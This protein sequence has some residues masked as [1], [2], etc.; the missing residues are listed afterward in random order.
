MVVWT[1][2][3]HYVVH[4]VA[5]IKTGR[6]TH[7][8]RTQDA[9]EIQQ[10]NYA[11]GG[12]NPSPCSP[13]SSAAPSAF[14]FPMFSPPSMQSN[15]VVEKMLEGICNAFRKAF[16]QTTYMYEHKDKVD[17]MT[18][19]ILAEQGVDQVT[20]LITYSLSCEPEKKISA[21]KTKVRFYNR[22]CTNN[23]RWINQVVITTWSIARVRCVSTK[24]TFIYFFK[25]KRNLVIMVGLGSWVR[26]LE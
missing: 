14:R 6:Y 10:I 1:L 21:L 20:N 12:S 15:R 4:N 23:Q 8:K 18:R 3:W 2:Q 19:C 24:L 16:P 7:T 22:Y 17:R 11:V 9:M 25:L 26:E 13:S 5:A